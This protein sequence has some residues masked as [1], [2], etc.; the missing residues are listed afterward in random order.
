MIFIIL[1]VL[2][3]FFLLLVGTDFALN[4]ISKLKRF[5]IGKWN[6]QKEWEIAVLRKACQWMKYTPTV[7]QTDNYRYVF[8]DMLEGKYRNATIQSWQIAGLVLGLSDIRDE[9]G[10]RIIDKWKRKIFDTYGMWK[11]PV[12]K[13]DFAMLGYAV[14]KTE[15]N[16][17]GIYPAMNWIVKM[18]ENNLCKDGMISY[19]QG[20]ESTI[21][22]VDTL[23][24]ICPFLALYGKIYKEEK[25][26][27]LSIN[28]IRK[29]R[30][31]GMYQSTQ[32]PCH[33]VSVDCQLPLGVYGWGRGTAW[34]MIGLIDT[35]FELTNCKEKT[36]MKAWIDDAAKEYLKYQ[37]EDG[38]FY[39]I[40]QG[41][42]QYDSSVTAVMAYF[43][44]KCSVVF[45][46]RKYGEIADR[47][48]ARLMKVTMKDGAIDQCQ[49][50]THGIG[51]FSQVFDVMPFVQGILLRSL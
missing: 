24:M 37:H 5:H 23:G 15:E 51:I 48:I 2:A 3:F 43:Y 22:F 9:R 38:S 50:D 6:N 33:A 13:V 27:T 34:Y 35:Y 39:T 26:V 7:R 20:K 49:G 10:K 42:G 18:L 46:D 21:R 47:C 45:D 41:G 8:L 25:Y 14:L 12:S 29:F 40:L 11:S 28:Q 1:S 44:R 36:E 30:E 4:H 17:E 31:I 32:L 19:S 16:P